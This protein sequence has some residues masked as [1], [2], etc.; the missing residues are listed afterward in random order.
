ME[1]AAFPITGPIG[2][3]DRSKDRR[4][5]RRDTEEAAIHDCTTA[6]RQGARQVRG[7]EIEPNLA[8][9]ERN[10]D[11]KTGDWR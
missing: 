1:F 8:E 3:V 9:L 5:G 7:R 10:A 11:C 2:T 6:G 4:R